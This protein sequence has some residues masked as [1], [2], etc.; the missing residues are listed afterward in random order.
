MHSSIFLKLYR[1]FISLL[2][3]ISLQFLLCSELKYYINFSGN[4]KLHL[5]YTYHPKWSKFST[6]F[7]LVYLFWSFICYLISKNVNGIFIHMYI[8]L[9]VLSWEC[10]NVRLVHFLRAYQW[11]LPYQQIN[12][13]LQDYIN[14]CRK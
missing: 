2:V 5:W 11:N 8:Y 7:L 4:V 1:L 13:T 10:G 14:R 3:E 6:F 9:L 12:K